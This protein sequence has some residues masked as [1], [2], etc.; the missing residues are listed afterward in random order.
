M[1]V[2]KNV[3]FFYTCVQKELL[4]FKYF[5]GLK[6]D[7]T[8]PLKGNVFKSLDYFSFDLKLKNYKKGSDLPIMISM[9]SKGYSS[10]LEFSVKE[11][12]Q[13]KKSYGLCF[14][15][16]GEPLTLARF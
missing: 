7:R 12:G 2:L 4:K 5:N 15:E 3:L 13:D 8:V 14:V 11:V 16:V 1:E 10:S 9:K 6:S